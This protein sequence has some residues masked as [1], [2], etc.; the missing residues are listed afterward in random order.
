MSLKIE[1]DSN[2]AVTT[3]FPNAKDQRHNFRWNTI[4]DV[5]RSPWL[6]SKTCWSG[7][8]RHWPDGCGQPLRG[9]SAG[10][11]RP[12][13]LLQDPDVDRAVGP[14]AVRC[15]CVQGFGDGVGELTGG[16]A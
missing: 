1:T 2:G 10:A 5:V 13:E 16:P 4:P 3:L 8:R 15:P 11:E 7:R 12:C 9:G 6:I 14:C